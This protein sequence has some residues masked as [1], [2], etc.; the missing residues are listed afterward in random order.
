M[1]GYLAGRLVYAAAF[2]S[3]PCLLISSLACPALLCAISRAWRAVLG[4]VVNAVMV[5]T[6]LVQSYHFYRDHGG[7]VGWWQDF[8]FLVSVLAGFVFVSLV[9]TMPLSRRSRPV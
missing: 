8:P 6:V 7:L 4:L 5:A 9:V 1:L 2:G 3:L